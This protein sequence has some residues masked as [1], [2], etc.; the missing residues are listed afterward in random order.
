[1]ATWKNS[2]ITWRAM[3]N[4]DLLLSRIDILENKLMCYQK[5]A[6]NEKLQ[7]QVSKPPIIQNK[8]VSMGVDTQ[9]AVLF[10]IYSIIPFCLFRHHKVEVPEPRK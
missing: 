8:H 2:S 3:V 9:I 1:M 4:E 5:N 10:N 6:T 7:E